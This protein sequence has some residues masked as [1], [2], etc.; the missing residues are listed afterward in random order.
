MDMDVWFICVHVYVYACPCMCVL[1]CMFMCICESGVEILCRPLLIL[2]I[3]SK[4]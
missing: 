1:M 4:G 3:L 2:L